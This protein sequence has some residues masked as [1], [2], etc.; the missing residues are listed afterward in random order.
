MS[1]DDGTDAEKRYNT[2]KRH[3]NIKMTSSESLLG[4]KRRFDHSLDTFTSVGHDRPIDELLVFRFMDALD[5]SRFNFFKIERFN[6]SR[7]V[8]PIALLPATVEE[9]F[10]AAFTHRT[11]SLSGSTSSAT[12]F[13]ASSKKTPKP[14]SKPAAKASS[15]KALVRAASAPPSAARELSRLKKCHPQLSKPMT[16]QVIFLSL[17]MTLSPLLCLMTLLSLMTWCLWT[18]YL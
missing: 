13:V 8:P 7:T 18:L 4:F 6:W 11:A 5:E 1:P 17:M 10:H 12:A 3:E 16:T 14:S 2:I 9:A 15:Y